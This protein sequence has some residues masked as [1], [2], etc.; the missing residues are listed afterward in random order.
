MRAIE[1]EIRQKLQAA[2][3]I[4]LSGSDLDRENPLIR[5]ARSTERYN[6]LKELVAFIDDRNTAIAAGEPDNDE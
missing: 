2:A 3:E 4:V 5:Y 1:R 6:T